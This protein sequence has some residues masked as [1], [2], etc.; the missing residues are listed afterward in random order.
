[1]NR[2][3]PVDRMSERRKRRA[4]RIPVAAVAVAGLALLAAGCGGLAGS[5]VAQLGATAAQSTPPSTAS[6]GPASAR[7]SAN[8][9]P[10]V[11]YSACMRSHGV[12][13]FPDPTSSGLLPKVG[14]QQLGVSNAQFQ[15]A[16]TTC[17]KLLPS[18]GSLPQQEHE[19]MQ[20]N[21]CP[22]ALVQ[23]MMNADRNL[24]QCMRAHGMPNFPDPVD[25]GPGGP[26]FPIAKAGISDAASHTAQFIAK[27]NQCGRLVGQD[28][29][30]SFG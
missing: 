13:K 29:P 10:A 8:S 19:C 28:A 20:N 1:M 16:E 14:L 15:S 3:A 26:Y 25:S 6:G 17:R 2:S 18:G 9:R 11:G 5:H 24:A 4:R 22:Q 30:E 21:D 12:L 23:Q 27:L 7:G